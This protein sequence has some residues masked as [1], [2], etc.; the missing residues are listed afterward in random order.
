MEFRHAKV[1]QNKVSQELYP[2]YRNFVAILLLNKSQYT[3]NNLMYR[4]LK[5]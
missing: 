4:W 5:I 3:P 1:R 2:S